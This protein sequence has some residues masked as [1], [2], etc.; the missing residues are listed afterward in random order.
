MVVKLDGE[1]TKQKHARQRLFLF[2][3]VAGYSNAFAIKTQQFLSERETSRPDRRNEELAKLQ[4]H[5]TAGQRRQCLRR[6]LK[7]QRAHHGCKTDAFV[8]HKC[9]CPE[10]RQKIRE[11]AENLCEVSSRNSEG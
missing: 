6:G 3:H 4:F 5:H 10:L 8:T 9:F 2:D 11:V 1:G 7:G